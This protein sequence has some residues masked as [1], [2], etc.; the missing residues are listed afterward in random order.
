MII[1]ECTGRA[2][3]QRGRFQSPKVSGLI[4]EYSRFRETV[5]GD[6]V[7]SRLP[8]KAGSQCL[9]G[10]EPVSVGWPG[11]ARP[12]PYEGRLVVDPIDDL[13]PVRLLAHRILLDVLQLAAV[14]VDRM[15][16]Q[17]R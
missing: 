1:H 7:R 5:A 2:N 6:L 17:A 15:D 11:Q 9:T 13:D 4:G 3:Q 16:G 12:L 14:L 10:F 8:Q